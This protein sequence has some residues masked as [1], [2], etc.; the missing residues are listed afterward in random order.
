MIKSVVKTVRDPVYGCIELTPFE[1]T[2]IDRPEFQ[3]LRFV[4]QQSA[5]YFTFP[6]NSN[7]RF[8]HSLGAMH[9]AGEMF[10]RILSNSSLDVLQKLASAGE[11]LVG[12]TLRTLR[13]G[14]EVAKTSLPEMRK[15][16]D[17]QIDTHLLSLISFP[18]RKPLTE[19]RARVFAFMWQ[20]VRLASLIHDLGHLPLSHLFEHSLFEYVRNSPNE[21]DQ[22]DTD[23]RGPVARSIVSLY[24]EQRSV[25]HKLAGLTLVAP[26]PPLKFKAN[27]RVPAIHEW[28]GLLLAF[29]HR[30]R[31]RHEIEGKAETL[32]DALIMA[33]RRILA[34]DDIIS[35]TPGHQG[36][37]IEHDGGWLAAIQCLHQLVSGSIDADRLDY[38]VRDAVSSA[39][40]HGAI[41]VGHIVRNLRVCEYTD[42]KRAKF[43]IACHQS[44]TQALESFF[45]QRFFEYRG[46][47]DHH[48]VSK[49][50]TIASEIVHRLLDI[51]SPNQNTIGTRYSNERSV[52]LANDIRNILVLR[53]FWTDNVGPN[54]LSVV[55][56][57]AQDDYRYFDDCWF[58]VLC[59]DIYDCCRR[60]DILLARP[61][62]SAA[63]GRAAIP[64]DNGLLQ[65][66]ALVDTFL[67]R[68]I[69]NA[70]SLWK[71]EADYGRFVTAV[72]DRV[73][74]PSELVFAWFFGVPP[75]PSEREIQAELSRRD[76]RAQSGL[77][78]DAARRNAKA[79]A[80]ELRRKMREKQEKLHST[81]IDKLTE[82]TNS[83]L[84]VFFAEDKDRNADRIGGHPP[85]ILV[86]HVNPRIIE[87]AT[88]E[89]EHPRVPVLIE[90]A[91][92]VQGHLVDAV[93]ASSALA[94]MVAM[95][96][97]IPRLQVFF[98][99]EYLREACEKRKV[100]L[101][102]L[103]VDAAVY[104]ALAVSLFQ[105]NE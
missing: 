19:Q 64:I 85:A 79:V 16:I 34:A 23:Q 26:I 102:A 44:S 76:R 6:N 15:A 87:T 91:N 29:R 11:G 10:E 59:Q 83:K 95:T 9:L 72:S 52:S 25:A 70:I 14:D 54:C 42:G 13:G 103:A 65:I 57:A 77:T 48:N 69:G 105:S 71:R 41:D 67:F 104:S 5:A 18:S 28:I 31:D 50:N 4:H 8:P 61:R 2:L 68:E 22:C 81:F 46:I 40:E 90:N 78:P 53:R 17:D 55:E 21:R 100:D 86:A 38:C 60:N 74:S 75:E 51:C 89:G 62:H 73:G 43:I 99:A 30:P 24:C 93:H 56:P 39:T 12:T 37:L 88:A 36:N 92:G 66:F 97:K 27:N 7:S 101:W 3:R 82:R 35:I 98:C 63:S 45:F 32:R 33:A 20:S 1:Q 80:E 94:G 96:V 47:V 58:R 49:F 84:Q